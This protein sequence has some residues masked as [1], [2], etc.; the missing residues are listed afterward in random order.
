MQILKQLAMQ[1]LELKCF[2]FWIFEFYTHVHS[3]DWLGLL[4]QAILVKKRDTV[5]VGQKSLIANF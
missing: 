1:D 2:N 3:L 4:I 5:M